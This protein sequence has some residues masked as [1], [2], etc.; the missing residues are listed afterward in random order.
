MLCATLRKECTD[1]TLPKGSVFMRNADKI[2]SMVFLT[3]MCANQDA[4]GCICCICMA[5]TMSISFI[6]CYQRDLS[7][8]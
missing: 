5:K 4:D 7:H 2:S 3:T 1:L 8:K 6:M